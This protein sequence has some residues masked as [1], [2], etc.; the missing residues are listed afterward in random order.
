MLLL[1][2]VV[3]TKQFFINANHYFGLLKPPGA[4]VKN[5][6]KERPE[7]LAE[8]LKVLMNCLSFIVIEFFLTVI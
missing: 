3:C 6:D 1:D 4:K 7:W 5:R 2:F 8:D